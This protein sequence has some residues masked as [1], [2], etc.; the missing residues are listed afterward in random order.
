MV[1]AIKDMSL[2]SIIVPCYN[3]IDYIGRLIESVLQ[4]TYANWELILVDDGSKDNTADICNQFL[5]RDVRI[6]YFYQ[7]NSGASSARNRGIN[8][9]RGEYICFADADDWLECSY[10]ENMINGMATSNVD[11]VVGGFKELNRGYIKKWQ[12]KNVFYTR[13]SFGTAVTYHD[14]GHLLL[15]PY[16]KLYKTDIIL[17]H[18]LHFPD[19]VRVGEDRIFVYQYMFICKSILFIG[20]LDYNYNRRSESV[21]KSIASFESV[22]NDYLAAEALLSETIDRCHIANNELGFLASLRSFHLQRML[23][24]LLIPMNIFKRAKYL[25]KIDGKSLLNDELTSSYKLRLIHTLLS[26]KLYFLTSL[27]ISL[28]CRSNKR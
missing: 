6:R 13:E 26:L 25:H 19:G 2:V 10:L 28:K 3:A 1:K 5:I 9:A 8:M 4:Q 7:K 27:M 14:T 22:Y 15:S 20:T 24:S 17:N 16:A 21:S 18:H 12:S 11:F 23:S